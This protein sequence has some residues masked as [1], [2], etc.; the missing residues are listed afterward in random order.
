MLLLLQVQGKKDVDDE[1]KPKLCKLDG[2]EEED[3]DENGVTGKTIKENDEGITGKTIKDGNTGKTIKGD[4]DD[5]EDGSTGMPTN[6]P[7][8][9]PTSAPTAPTSFLFS[10]PILQHRL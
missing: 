6:D 3:E 10:I 9:I 7:T 5:Y 8:S 1:S 2:H 4:E